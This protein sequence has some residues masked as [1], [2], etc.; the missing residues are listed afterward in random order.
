MMP[1]NIFTFIAMLLA[2]IVSSTSSYAKV[3]PHLD[4]H[5]VFWNPDDG[6]TPYP[7]DDDD[8]PIVELP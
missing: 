8:I 1:L 6:D 5:I 7:D 3:V 2:L 4:N